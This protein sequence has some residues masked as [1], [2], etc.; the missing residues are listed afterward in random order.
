VDLVKVLRESFIEQVPAMSFLD[1]LVGKVF[2]AGEVWEVL[3]GLLKA[4]RRADF[5]LE[6]LLANLLDPPIVSLARC[7]LDAGEPLIL[8]VLLEVGGGGKIAGDDAVY[9]RVH[10]PV[11]EVL[12]QLSYR[13]LIFGQI[14][15]EIKC[16]PFFCPFLAGLRLTCIMLTPAQIEGSSQRSASSDAR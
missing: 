12:C 2:G 15:S 10:H 4:T 3:V 16:T 1:K 13:V 14:S 6:L 7:I 11:K 8:A 9:D 5:D